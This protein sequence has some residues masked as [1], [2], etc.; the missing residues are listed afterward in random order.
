[1]ASFPEVFAIWAED[2]LMGRSNICSQNVCTSA[3]KNGRYVSD[4]INVP[5]ELDIK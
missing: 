1:M 4:Q 3:K 2:D 5:P